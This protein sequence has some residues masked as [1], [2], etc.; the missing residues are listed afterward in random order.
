MS[1]VKRIGG[2]CV[3]LFV[4]SVSTPSWAQYVFHMEGGTVFKKNTYDD[5]TWDTVNLKYTYTSPVIIAIPN[6]NGSNPADFRIRNIT[7]NS[8]ELTLAEPPSEDGPHWAMEISYIVVE[9]GH[10][11][12]PDGQ[13]LTAGFVNTNQ[14]VH[15]WGGGFQLV[16]LPSG[17]STPI[18]LP[19]IQS[20]ANEQNQLP[21][22]TSNPW[23]TT[24]VRNVAGPSFE[25]AL[26]G[27]ECTTSQ[28]SAQETIGYLA[29]EGGVTSQFVDADG[30]TVSYETILTGDVVPGWDYGTVNVGFS[31]A[32]SAVPRFVAKLQ[33]RNENDGGWVRFESLAQGSVELT[34]DEDQC[35]DSERIHNGEKAGLFVFSQDFRVED[36]DPDK[37]GVPYPPDNCPLVY[38]PQQEDADNDGE[39][40]ACDC[41]DGVVYSGEGCDDGNTAAGDGCSTS[42]T[43]ETGWSCVGE[44]SVCVPIC[45]D[46]LLRGSEGCDDGGTAGGDGCSASCTV[47]TGWTCVG[48][49]SVCTA[50]CGDGLILGAEG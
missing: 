48:E 25:L 32:Y 47:E 5:P 24:A 35:Y 36:V 16:G 12:L 6:T 21:S 23:L 20:L 33:T 40:D 19:Q 44:P 46:G 7:T 50:I 28:P 39:G 13:Q 1:W 4:L 2:A 43:V 18:V 29:I 30:L 37:D 38:N 41:G 14:L 45:G 31:H 34:V 42:C 17:Y 22:Q 9:K 27:C 26:D 49:P 11:L 10:W 8:F 3:A 15:K